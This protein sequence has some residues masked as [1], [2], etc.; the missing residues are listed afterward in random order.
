[1]RVSLDLAL[2]SL[3][4]GGCRQLAACLFRRDRRWALDERGV[5]QHLRMKVIPAGTESDDSRAA[6]RCIWLGGVAHHRTPST[7]NLASPP[8]GS[9][10]HTHTDTPPRHH[11]C[12][13]LVAPPGASDEEGSQAGATHTP[14]HTSHPRH[15]RACPAHLVQVAPSSPGGT[16]RRPYGGSVQRRSRHARQCAE[17][18]GREGQTVVERSS[19]HELMADVITVPRPWDHR[20]IRPWYVTLAACRSPRLIVRWRCSPEVG[21]VHGVPPRTGGGDVARPLGCQ[22]GGGR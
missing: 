11:H 10:R 21:P 5:H 9:Q 18:I 7:I 8:L 1:M 12:F 20:T 2:A 16:V 4:L 3:R 13:V 22:L 14:R 6:L 17:L 15:P 19:I